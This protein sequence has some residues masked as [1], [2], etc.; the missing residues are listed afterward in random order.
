[1]K[2]ILLSLIIIV[3]GMLAFGVINVSAETEGIYTYSVSNGMAT[4]TDCSSSASGEIVIPNTLGGYPVETIGDSAFSYCTRL[5]GVTI[6]DSVTTVGNSAFSACRSVTNITIGNRVTTIGDSAFSGCEKLTSITIPSSVKTIGDSAFSNCIGLVKVNITSIEAWCNIDFYISSSNPL[7]RA[8]KLY[9]NDELVTNLIIPDSV[10]TINDYAFYNC[11]SLTS[12]TMSNSVTTINDYAFYYCTELKNA[13]IGDSVTTIGNYAFY[14]CSGLTS[15]TVGDNVTAICDSAFSGCSRLTSIT[16]PD[17]VTTIGNYTFSGCTGLTKITIGNGIKTIGMSTFNNC[18]ALTSVYITDIE[19]WCNIDFENAYANPFSCDVSLYLN[20]QLT[21]SITI[22]ESIKTIKKYSFYMAYIRTLNMSDSVEIIEDQAFYS[23]RNM[24][25]I[26][27]SKNLKS[28]GKQ[29]FY[30]CGIM[31]LYIPDK[32]ETIGK[33][34]FAQCGDMLD[35]RIPAKINEIP[36]SAF[37]YCSDLVNVALL[38]NVEKIGNNAFYNCTFIK[39]V[40][41]GGTETDYQNMGVGSNNTYLT[42]ARTFYN[43]RYSGD[44]KAMM[45]VENCSYND[46]VLDYV[47]KIVPRTYFSGTFIIATYTE[48]NQLLDIDTKSFWVAYSSHS[49]E[50]VTIQNSISVSAKPYKYKIFLWDSL[51]TLLPLSNTYEGNI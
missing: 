22:P 37:Y 33:E 42:N 43:C 15:I 36:D 41:Y 16:I 28:I 19:A 30:N 46:G 38:G 39:N 11:T 32:V 5:T 23:C 8:K 50:D 17:S 1:M 6:P 3:I 44:W 9:L 40:F 49:I 45:S 34:A 20:K 4:I 21:T 13:T 10:T 35:V 25:S 47:V 2:K 18:T 7:S 31:S 27:L 48:N 51:N 14:Y 24:T 29:A 26:T 12:V